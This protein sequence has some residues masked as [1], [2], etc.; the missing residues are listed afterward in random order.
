MVLKW[1]CPTHIWL[2][3]LSRIG[4][5]EP[6]GDCRQIVT[7]IEN[8]DIHRELQALLSKK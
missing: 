1:R 2:W 4:I 3:L 7:L 8:D 5:H 6:E